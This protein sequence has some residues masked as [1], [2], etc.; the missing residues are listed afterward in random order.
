MKEIIEK[1][2][3][4]VLNGMTR[5]F[6]IQAPDTIEKLLSATRLICDVFRNDGKILVCGNGGSMCDAMHFAEEFTGRFRRDRKPLPAIALS[7]PA[8]LTCVGNDFGFEQ[9][10][11][12]SVFALGKK[13]DLLVAISTSGHSMNVIN[14]VKAAKVCE[15]SIIGLLGKEGG[16][17][18][19]FCDISFIPPGNTSDR[20]QEIHMIIL[21]IL[22]ECVERVLFPENCQLPPHKC[23]SL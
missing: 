9:V 22:I 16:M 7:D 5:F 2:S 20:I 19:Q 23:G 6:S 13:G 1:A 17:V 4:D 8:H 14:A 11:A 15:M 18:K 3:L 21:H 10:F 12:R